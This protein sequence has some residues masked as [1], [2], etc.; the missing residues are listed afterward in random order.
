MIEM[1]KNIPQAAIFEFPAS[2]LIIVPLIATKLRQTN[3]TMLYGR[4]EKSLYSIQLTTSNA[5]H[6]CAS[7]KPLIPLRDRNHT[8]DEITTATRSFICTIPSHQLNCLSILYAMGSITTP[9]PKSG[10][11]LTIT[12][13]RNLPSSL[14]L[15]LSLFLFFFFF[16]AYR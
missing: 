13:A 2:N 9:C 4:A 15:S 8:N 11:F 14:S 16:S 3:V 1:I 6:R 10:P 12:L 5:A 7:Q